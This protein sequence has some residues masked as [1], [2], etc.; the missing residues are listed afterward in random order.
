MKTKKTMVGIILLFVS[1]FLLPI[2]QGQG[3]MN[4][5]YNA[6]SGKL[7][8][9]PTER[10]KE[11]ILK[12]SNKEAEEA[13]YQMITLTP[14]EE[15]QVRSGDLTVVVEKGILVKRAVVKIITENQKA[16]QE[17]KAYI[18]TAFPELTDASELTVEEVKKHTTIGGDAKAILYQAIM[19]GDFNE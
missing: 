8:Q 12:A 11:Q 10:T 9:D 6:K 16:K 3:A 13:E 17:L 1:Y 4:F 2:A 18:L 14:A 5:L 19:N 7:I 15:A